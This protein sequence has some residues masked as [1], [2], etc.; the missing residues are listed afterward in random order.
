MV[1]GWSKSNSTTEVEAPLTTA[2]ATGVA[3]RSCVAKMR[4]SES[5][6]VLKAARSPVMRLPL[7]SCIL[8][9]GRRMAT[10]CV[11]SLVLKPTPLLRS[12]CSVV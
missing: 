9:S 11:A 5:L 7:S 4:S 2:S 10:P 8:L 12:Y 1:M 3:V 6:R